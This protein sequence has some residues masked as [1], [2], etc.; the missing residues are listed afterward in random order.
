MLDKE[1]LAPAAASIE[2]KFVAE[3]LIAARLLHT[4]GNTYRTLGL[5][6]PAE[7]YHRQTL[8]TRRRV[9]GEDHPDTLSS[10]NSL[11]NV[12]DNQGRYEEAE[13]L[14]RQTLETR[15]RVLGEDHPNTLSSMNSLAYVYSRQGHY[16][17]AEALHRQTLETRRRVL[18]ED[19]PNTLSTMNNLVNVYKATAEVD[20]ARPLVAELLFAKKK[21]SERSDANAKTKNSYAWLALTRE[22]A[23]LRDPES[24]FR[25]ALEANELTGFENPSFLDTLALA[26][27]MTG[28]TAKAIEIQKR[29]L[30]LLPEGDS[31][32]RKEFEQRLAEFEVALNHS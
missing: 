14:H 4:I 12:Y 32:T 15:R 8:E 7:R 26:Y 23:D 20:K 29:A 13:A 10:M 21:T 30:A 31:P 5:Y 9:L 2:E 18:G 17:E 16:E 19:H 25:F 1:I 28:N 11:A 3:P 24:A 22:P 6:E 27:Q